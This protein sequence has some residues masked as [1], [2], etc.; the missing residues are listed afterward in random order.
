MVT[1]SRNNL[2]GRSCFSSL[3]VKYNLRPFL[4]LCT[5]DDWLLAR[6]SFVLLSRA[7]TRWWTRSTSFILLFLFSLSLFLIQEIAYSLPRYVVEVRSYL[8]KKYISRASTQSSRNINSKLLVGIYFYCNRLHW[9][10][11]WNFFLFLRSNRR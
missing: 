1:D 3:L 8:S 9:K 7:S 5:S 2:K 6:L 10:I 11:L 4:N